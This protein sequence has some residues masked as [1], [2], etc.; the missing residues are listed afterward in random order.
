MNIED[1][2]LY[3]WI[4]DHTKKILQETEG[5]LIKTSYTGKKYEIEL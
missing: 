3:E 1:R 2:E 4:G 5:Q